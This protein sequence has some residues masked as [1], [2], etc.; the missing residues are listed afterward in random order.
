MSRTNSRTLG[1]TLGRGVRLVRPGR[2]LRSPGLSDGHFFS[3]RMSDCPT[4]TKRP[5]LRGVLTR[6]SISAHEGLSDRSENAT[7]VIPPHRLK[8]PEKPHV[9]LSRQ[10]ATMPAYEMSPRRPCT[11]GKAA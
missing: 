3:I 7:E 5:R 6:T 2:L 9:G 8:A 11:C 1:R 4:A 10:V